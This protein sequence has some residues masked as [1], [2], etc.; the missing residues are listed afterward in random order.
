MGGWVE[1]G[2]WSEEE[3]RKGGGGGEGMQTEHGR[4]GKGEGGWERARE[5]DGNAGGNVGEPLPPVQPL[6]TLYGVLNRE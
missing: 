5:E 4:E 3:S 1:K 2:G 6:T